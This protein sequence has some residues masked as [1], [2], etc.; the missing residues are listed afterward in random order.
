MTDLEPPKP[1]YRLT[2]TIEGNSHDEVERE[3]L[4]MT[5]GGYLLDSDYYKRDEWTVYGGRKTSRMQ[6]QNPEMTPEQYA[7]DLDAWS[8]AR[9]AARR[10]D[11]SA[12]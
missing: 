5:R 12:A 10:D 6:H 1:K 9:R 11:G 2:L 3:L 7:S 4:I 8:D